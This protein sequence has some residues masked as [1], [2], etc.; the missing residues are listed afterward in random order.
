[1]RISRITSKEL[2]NLTA[3]EFSSLYIESILNKEVENITCLV[4]EE[5]F[6]NKK[7]LLVYNIQ[8]ISEVYHKLL[9]EKLKMSF[10]VS[11][12]YINL[13]TNRLVIDWSLDNRNVERFNLAHW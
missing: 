6:Y 9:I 10:L 8:H 5:Q 3:E 12:I 11:S 1:M 4:L 13:T 2:K 7:E